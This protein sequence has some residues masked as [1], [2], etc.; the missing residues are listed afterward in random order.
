MEV[1]YGLGRHKA[2]VSIMSYK[3]YLKYDLVDWAQVCRLQ[4]SK[5]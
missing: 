3:M 1:V 5:I 4:R 2:A